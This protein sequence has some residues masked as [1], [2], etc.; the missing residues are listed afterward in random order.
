MSMIDSF[1]EY[2]TNE[3]PNFNQKWI[4]DYYAFTDVDIQVLERINQNLQKQTI[5]YRSNI[6]LALPELRNASNMSSNNKMRQSIKILSKTQMIE[7]EA[8][9]QDLNNEYL[10]K[11]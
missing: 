3:I 2:I 5:K 6:N 4:T 9:L 7:E 8:K 11:Q 10:D 1:N